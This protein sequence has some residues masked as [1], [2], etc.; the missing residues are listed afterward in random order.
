MAFFK[1]RLPGQ[2][3]SEAQANFT[4]TSA[5]SVD[6][7]RRRARHRLIG[8][9]VL[10]LVAVVVFP[11]VFDTQPR[12]ISAD[13]VIDIPDR[14]QA[15]PLAAA[16]A[17]KALDAASALDP[18]EEIVPSKPVAVSTPVAAPTASREAASSPE[19]TKPQ[20]KVASVVK[21]PSHVD[22]PAKDTKTEP[23]D[24]GRFVVQVGAFSDEAKSKE[25][26]A[27]LEKAGIKTYIHIA[28]T[29]EGKRTRVRVGPFNTREEADK[30]AN[31]IKQLQLQPQVLTL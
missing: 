15:K 11:M 18:K 19:A 24:V 3:G 28:D 13:V 4:P 22:A 12:S 23:K 6:E 16:S 7:L 26:R 27:K 25:V 1:F 31:K 2:S 14:A 29:K 30:V 20:T 5:Q 8:S 21:A 10:V 17:P 9:A